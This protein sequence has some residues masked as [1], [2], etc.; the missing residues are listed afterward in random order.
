[1]PSPG[2]I[3]TSLCCLLLVT[4]AWG[5]ENVVTSSQAKDAEEAISL[6]LSS[7]S[8][9]ASWNGFAN[10]VR[11]IDQPDFKRIYQFAGKKGN[12]NK[13]AQMLAAADRPEVLIAPLVEIKATRTLAA[14]A[15]AAEAM[16]LRADIDKRTF[17]AEASEATQTIEPLAKAPK[18]T[19][20][21]KRKPKK[22]KDVA[23]DDAKDDAKPAQ[24]ANADPRVA[25]LIDLLAEK[26]D[27]IRE[28]AMI[29]AAQYGLKDEALSAAMDAV[30]DLEG[31]M[32]GA[33][34][35]YRARTGAP[36]TADELNAAF[37]KI[38]GAVPE[39]KRVDPVLADML[40]RVPTP[41][42]ACQAIGV[43]AGPEHLPLLHEALEHD[44]IRVRVD[45]A[46]A[47]ADI[48]DQSSVPVLIAQL[49]ECEWPVLIHVCRGLGRAPSAES[50][51]P[52]IKELGDHKGRFRIDLI[53][54]LSSIA[55]SQF[56]RQTAEQWAEWWNEKKA[57]DFTVDP[58]ATADFRSKNR[59]Q[60][61]SIVG[62][63]SFYGLQVP[64]DRFVFVLDRSASMRGDRIDN[65]RETSE[66]SITEM[67]NH[68]QFNI[69]DF[70]GRV[71]WFSE[72][73]LSRDR[74][75]AIKYITNMPLTWGTRTFDGVE[76]GVRHRG[77]DSIVFLS[78]GSPVISQAPR[79]DDIF[80][81]T[82][83]MNR[84][85]PVAVWAVCFQAGKGA[86]TSM[87][88][89]AGEH[90]GRSTNIE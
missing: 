70:G 57:E 75:D 39:I 78:D 18:K 36:I 19:S 66:A 67:A 69:V 11:L 5:E 48:A 68:V 45:A 35:L 2:A 30:D 42:L 54:A 50:I 17:M 28:H 24:P 64:S 20:K 7:K 33:R 82:N 44:D 3:F 12:L 83:M 79:W 16:M 77:I 43:I 51:E 88:I 10:Y 61:M 90:F 76:E 23:D 46:T 71:A 62:A 26:N 84:Y 73:G 13:A 31:A 58:A 29:A 21:N 53:H 65:L 49:G 37:G 47:I 80:T 85:R 89:W 38:K 74:K 81:A 72:S 40:V 87:D 41:A 14:R 55:G 32:L 60:D 1:M 8:Q 59:V 86:A 34:L 52:L 56:G 4:A 6:A 27:D 15:L 22:Q 63:L 9:G 25:W